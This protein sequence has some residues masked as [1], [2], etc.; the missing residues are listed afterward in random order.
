MSKTKLHLL[1]LRAFNA[2]NEALH[3]EPDASEELIGLLASFASNS[4]L[5]LDVLAEFIV[6]DQKSVLDLLL[7]HVLSQEFVEA[8]GDLAL[9]QFF[10][11]FHG[12][13]GVL[14]LGES[15]KLDNRVGALSVS[16]ALVEL[17]KFL[18][19]LVLGDLEK[20]EAGGRLK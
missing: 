5:L 11:G 15:L 8:L 1:H 2:F 20:S 10:D 7:D 12:I 17:V 13:L 16:E 6:S 14:E 3:L 19:F 4:E 18:K 9:H